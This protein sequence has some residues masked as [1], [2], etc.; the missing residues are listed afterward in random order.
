ML[1]CAVRRPPYDTVQIKRNPCRIR[2]GTRSRVFQL[3]VARASNCNKP[4]PGGRF[5]SEWERDLRHNGRHTELS[6]DAVR[7]R[8]CRLRLPAHAPILPRE[9]HD[10]SGDCRDRC[11]WRRLPSTPSASIRSQIYKDGIKPEQVNAGSTSPHPCGIPTTVINPG[12]DTI[13]I[14]GANPSGCGPRTYTHKFDTPGKY[15]VICSVTPHFLIKMYGWV[16]VRDRG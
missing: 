2:I 1:P 12:A 13:P 7:S 11:R 8:G 6:N 4:R 15:L 10:C 3:R 14:N 16:T 5:R 9:R